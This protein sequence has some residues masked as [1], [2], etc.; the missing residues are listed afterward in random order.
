[1]IIFLNGS[2]NSGKTTIGKLL[3][4][5][6]PNTALLEIDTLRD[7]VSWMPLEKSIPLNLQN[8]ISLIKNF[9]SQD[10]N[11]I[12]SYPISQ[13]NYDF[14]MRELVNINTPIH[15]FTLSPSLETILENRG[16]RELNDWEIERIKYHYEI[17]INNPAFGIVIDNTAQ[18]PDETCSGILLN[19][20]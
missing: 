6:L 8:S 1:M 3:Q 19:L 18:T 7:M 11:V 14:F 2:I 9:V 15:F 5:K 16:E 20:K 4:N 17:G 13:N 10:L 12:V